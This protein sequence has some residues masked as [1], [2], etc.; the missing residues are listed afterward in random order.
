MLPN[1]VS[2]QYSLFLARMFYLILRVEKTKAE[3]DKTLQE[4][5]TKMRKSYNE[6]TEHIQKMNHGKP[7]FFTTYLSSNA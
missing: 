4:E 3:A 5:E 2:V 7:L 6:C 1:D